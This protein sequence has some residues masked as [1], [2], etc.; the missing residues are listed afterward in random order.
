MRSIFNKKNNYILFIIII[1]LYFFLS[2]EITRHSQWHK[3]EFL[4]SLF[5]SAL[6]VFFLCINRFLSVIF[7][8]FFSILFIFN[9]YLIFKFGFISQNMLLAIS[10]TNTHEANSVLSAVNPVFWILGL[11]SV[12]IVLYLSWKYAKFRPRYAALCVIFMIYPILHVLVRVN[13]IHK[14]HSLISEKIQDIAQSMPGYIGNSLYVISMAFDPENQIQ[15]VPHSKIDPM[16]IGSNGDRKHN[17]IL[18]IGESD[19]SDRH[20]IYGYTSQNTT[21]NANYY[22]KS[23]KLCAIRNVHSSANMTRYAVPML[24]SFY[25]PDHQD[26]IYS[27]KNLIELAKDNGYQTYWIASSEGRGP[28]ARPFGYLS[29]FSQYVTRQDYNNTQNHVDWHDE[30][31]L[32]V[33]KDKFSDKGQY[34]FFVIHLVG[35]HMDYG[36]KRTQEDI[37]AL[38]HADSYDQSIHRTDRIIKQIVDMADKELHDYILLYTSDHG[39]VVND[40]HMS[41]S[42]HGLQYGG[43]AQYRIP[44]F[45]INAGPYCKLAENLRNQ[46]GYFTE[47]MDKFLLLDMMGYKISPLAIKE[48]QVNDRVIHSDGMVY[49][50]KDIPTKDHNK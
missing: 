25:D 29:E 5:M 30:S 11:T 50:Y 31:I 41:Q 46:D 48:L 24:V 42:G 13:S 23:G 32:P 47:A 36:D 10:G 33:I 12:A 43:Y 49:N 8:T 17:I 18:I 22:Q 28:Y 1:S 14:G 38:P 4:F 2:Y 35:S 9:W 6:P 34:K 27:E 21:P 45:L 37:T 44:T 40:G 15:A 3:K 39:E 16:V 7:F 19:I 20:N 26:K